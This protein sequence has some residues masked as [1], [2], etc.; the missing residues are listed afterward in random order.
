MTHAREAQVGIN[1]YLQAKFGEEKIYLHNSINSN[2][3]E[4]YSTCLSE[5][6]PSMEIEIGN[7]HQLCVGKDHKQM[8]RR[9]E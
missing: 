9:I 3:L 6:D 4:E 2:I 7:G 1:Y 5:G 8:D